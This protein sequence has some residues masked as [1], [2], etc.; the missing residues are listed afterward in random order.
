[1]RT[2]ITFVVVL[3]VLN[4]VLRGGTAYWKF[5]QFKD[6]TQEMVVFGARTPTSLLHEQVFDKATKLEVPI[7]SDDIKVTREGSRTV[8]SASYEQTV[9]F[10]PRYTRPLKFSFSV[11]GELQ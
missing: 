10:F 9:E 2:I 11:A 7:G 1:M 5:Y 6:A 4:A 3:V 8:V